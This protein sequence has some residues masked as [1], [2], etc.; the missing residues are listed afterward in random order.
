MYKF[1][2]LIDVK[3]NWPETSSF[4]SA[5]IA[6]LSSFFQ[7]F[8]I[9]GMYD[10][11]ANISNCFLKYRAITP[12]TS[13]ID[14]NRDHSRFDFRMDIPYLLNGQYFWKWTNANSMKIK[15]KPRLAGKQILSRKT[16]LGFV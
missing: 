14:S 15:T 5:Q 3:V 10:F 16:R 9:L 1:F 7:L 6:L 13:F 8:M 2:P 11:G 4:L 12:S